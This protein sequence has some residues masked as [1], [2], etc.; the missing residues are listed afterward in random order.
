[1]LAAGWATNCGEEFDNALVLETKLSNG[2]ALSKPQNNALDKVRT[3]SN[4]FD[5]RSVSQSGIFNPI[6]NSLGNTDKIIITDYIK[7]YSD[8][9]GTSVQDIISLK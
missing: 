1:M 3:A 9:V 7:V 2:T 4:R 8:G 5:V 6:V